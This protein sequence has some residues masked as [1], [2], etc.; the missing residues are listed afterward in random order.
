MT[1]LTALQLDDATI[2]AGDLEEQGSSPDTGENRTF[3]WG[4]LLLRVINHRK[5]RGRSTC[6][7]E[8]RRVG[9]AITQSLQPAGEQRRIR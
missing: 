8:G 1:M 5:N 4:Y 7:R 3:W 9:A 6:N 2:V